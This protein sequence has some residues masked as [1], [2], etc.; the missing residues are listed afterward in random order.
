VKKLQKPRQ[1]H[2]LEIREG[3][4]A[5]THY[6]TCTC[7]QRFARRSSI[8]TLQGMARRHREKHGQVLPENPAR[9]VP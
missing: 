2:E 5:G 6:M 3:T 9:V 4:R 1:H 8:N 7:G